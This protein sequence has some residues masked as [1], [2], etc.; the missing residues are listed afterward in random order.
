MLP[1]RA[2][3][4]GSG[5]TIR[6]SW[7]ALRRKPGFLNLSAAMILYFFV[8]YGAVMFFPSFM[9]RVYGEELARIGIIFGAMSAVASLA[10]SVLGGFAVDRLAM[11]DQRWICW[12]P[13]ILLLIT[14]PLQIGALLMPS[15]YGFVAV[16]FLPSLIIAALIPSLFTHLH[17][18]CG[19]PRRA[20]AVAI[21]FF[22]A[23]LIGL[24]LGPV[25]AGAMSDHFTA[26]Q[27]PAGIRWSLVIVVLLF[28]PAG[29]LMLRA[30]RTL[31]TDIEP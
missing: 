6:E 26:L 25:I 12:T 13:G 15:F 8:S 19:S 14:A 2:V 5:E 28:I 23:N 16:C 31:V 20:T 10:G 7:Q 21:M 29:I 18:I 30:A 22:F 1:G 11:R 17:A 27:G 24:G 9:M 3:P 4:R